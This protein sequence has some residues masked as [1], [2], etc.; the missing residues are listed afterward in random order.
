MLTH[1]RMSLPPGEHAPKGLNPSSSELSVA[2]SNSL[3]SVAVTAGA[4]LNVM[5]GRKLAARAESLANMTLELNVRTIS[6]QHERLK[7]DIE[8][9]IR[10]TQDD[11][12]FRDKNEGRLQEVFKELTALNHHMDR[13]DEDQRGVKVS[14]EELQKC[15]TESVAVVEEFRKEMG[16]VR[17]VLEGL[18][19]QMDAL[20]S[21]MSPVESGYASQQP[22]D[23]L[24]DTR[25]IAAQPADRLGSME[26]VEERPRL[27]AIK[28][29]EL[30]IEGHDEA[31]VADAARRVSE[32]IKSTR[33]WHHDH[34][35][36]KLPDGEFCYNYLRQ[37]SKR[38]AKVAVYI[39]RTVLRRIIRRRGRSAV[40]PKSLDDFC[41]VV[42]WEDI[43]STV[44]DVLIKD[45]KLAIISII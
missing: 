22:G 32:A 24:G 35:T 28:S 19:K 2:P 14:Q 39:Q 42:R 23:P 3:P 9:L 45:E 17:A 1:R 5:Q 38:D 8:A 4:S 36:T 41:R 7:R 13:V 25:L 10:A 30:V 29:E 21:T 15:Q 16:D 33:R 26:S 34:K 37:Q 43:V 6:H 40:R 31:A 20:S 11:Q 18:S 44:R 27:P 12:E